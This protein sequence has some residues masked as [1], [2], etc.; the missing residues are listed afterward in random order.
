MIHFLETHG[1]EVMIAYYLYI[2]A[3]SSM[4]PLPDSAGYYRRWA[5]QFMHMFAGNWE[6]VMA[7]LK[8]PVKTEDK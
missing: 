2:S 6:K 7:A 3:V 1:I 5:F 4:P 8:L